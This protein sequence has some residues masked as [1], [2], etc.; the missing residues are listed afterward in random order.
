[1]STQMHVLIAE[2]NIPNQRIIT[3]ILKSFGCTVAVATNGAEALAAMEE[4]QFALVLM[5][6]RMPEMDGIEATRL[7]RLRL[8][9]E[10]Q[11]AI[12]ALTAGVSE[13]ERNACIEAGM[14]GFVAK[15]IDRAELTALLADLTPHTT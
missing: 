6:V 9:A 15:P 1:M 13:A 4:Q 14:N 3:H 10:A 5:D 11:P 2:D 8:P 7:A 12:Y